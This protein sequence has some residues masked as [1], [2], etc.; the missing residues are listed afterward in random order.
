MLKSLDALNAAQFQDLLFHGAAGLHELRSIWAN[1][2]HCCVDTVLICRKVF[3]KYGLVVG[4]PVS[5]PPQ[6]IELFRKQNSLR[7][8]ARRKS[9]VKTGRPQRVLVPTF[10]ESC[11]EAESESRNRLS[12]VSIRSVKRARLSF[13]VLDDGLTPFVQDIN[14]GRFFKPEF[15]L[16]IRSEGS[17]EFVA[18]SD[19]YVVKVNQK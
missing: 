8:R 12:S 11:P 16:K 15:V 17:I 6:A 10:G 19:F 4:D 9:P 14:K 18:K 1:Q 3:V 5:K 2:F 7:R 13:D